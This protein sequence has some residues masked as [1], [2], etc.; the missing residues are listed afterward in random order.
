MVC[1]YCGVPG[2]TEC[3]YCMVALCKDCS[4]LDVCIDCYWAEQNAKDNTPKS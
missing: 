3:R 2:I 4:V 1:G